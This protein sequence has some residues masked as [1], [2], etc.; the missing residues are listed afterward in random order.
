MKRSS[1]AIFAHRALHDGQAKLK[2]PESSWSIRPVT[3]HPGIRCTAVHTVKR[4]IYFQMQD[5]YDTESYW[6]ILARTGFEITWMVERIYDRSS[7]EGP[8]YTEYTALVVNGRFFETVEQ[9]EMA[10]NP[11]YTS[12]V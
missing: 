3:D 4:R 8:G 10:I 5:P 9:A 11:G 2:L 1:L 7:D 12:M 6:S